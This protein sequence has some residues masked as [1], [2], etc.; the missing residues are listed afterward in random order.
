VTCSC[1]GAISVQDFQMV[2]GW[3]AKDAGVNA[4]ILQRLSQGTDHPVL[5]SFPESE[6]LK[7]MIMR[8]IK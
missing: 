1:S 8:V 2:L 6:Y 5:V 4:Q 3:A 7:V